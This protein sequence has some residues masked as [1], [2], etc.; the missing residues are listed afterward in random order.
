M[1]NLN[2]MLFNVW[3]GKCKQGVR[4][5]YNI[6]DDPRLELIFDIILLMTANCEGNPMCEDWYLGILIQT[7]IIT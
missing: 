6:I 4:L 2:I 5:S 7:A 3:H 1:K